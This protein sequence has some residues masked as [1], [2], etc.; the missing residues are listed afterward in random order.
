MRELNTEARKIW[1]AE[2]PIEITQDGM[3]Q[4]QMNSRVGWTFAA[5]MRTFL[6]ADPDVIMIGEMR[7]EETA[8]IAIEASLT[9]HL[10][11]STLH[12]NSAPES[13]AR[14][15]EI[16]LDP[17]NFSDSL[18]AI[19]AQ[20]LVR[21][22]CMHCREAE[23]AGEDE[24]DA[25]AGQYLGDGLAADPAGRAALRWRWQ[26]E[27]ADEHGRIRLYRRRGCEQCEGHGCFGR[28]GIH[29][30]MVADETIRKHIR[31]RE[32][33]HVVQAAALAAGM[34]TLRQ[35]GIDKVLAGLTDL[36]EVIAAAQAQRR[37]PPSAAA[38]RI[39][40]RSHS[41]TT[42]KDTMFDARHP[43]AP[44][45]SGD[46]SRYPTSLVPTKIPPSLLAKVGETFAGALSAL[47]RSLAALGP[48][49][50]DQQPVLDTG[51]AEVGRLEHLGVQI[52]ELA[53]VLGG[54]A[55]AAPERVDLARAAREAPAEWTQAARLKGISLAGPREPVELE[56]NAAV[57]EQLLD[58]GLEYA[59]HIGSSVEVSAG[60]QG[61]PALPMLTIQ[62]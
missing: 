10:V 53:R 13:I 1:S 28:L 44:I 49:A 45:H 58:L 36:S 42:R 11:L 24:L 27:R 7:D 60:L 6:R 22:L 18:L 26:S 52:Q 30:L 47:Q 35:D 43:D 56:V 8:H 54:D 15:L 57:L 61:Q 25:M 23:T 16:G 38:R 12:T 2:D 41:L 20:R 62:V 39:E 14:L 21:Q 37:H 19:L 46:P 50:R 5:A 29:E 32:D 51:L 59:L 48:L 9:G 31:H 4:V 55:P 3:R 33:A 34:Q 17:F 40:V